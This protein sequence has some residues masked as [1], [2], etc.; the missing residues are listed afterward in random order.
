[1]HHQPANHKPFKIFG[2]Y[3]LEGRGIHGMDAWDTRDGAL[4]NS[5][6]LSLSLYGPLLFFSEKTWPANMS[7]LCA[8]DE[9]CVS[10]EQLR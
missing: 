3:P 7:I 5:L 6:S 4:Y 10:T 2:F 9:Y 8:C 1:M